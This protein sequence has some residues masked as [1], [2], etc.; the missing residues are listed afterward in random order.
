VVCLNDTITF[1]LDGVVDSGGIKRVDCTAKTGI[2]P[3]EPTITWTITKPDGTTISGS[4]RVAAVPADMA[5]TYTCTFGASADRDCPPPPITIGPAA[6]TAQTAATFTL[7]PSSIPAKTAWAGM[8]ANSSQSDITVTWDPP[9]CVGRL[10]I[11]LLEGTGGYQ[12]PNQGALT[13]ENDTLWHYVAFDE[14][15]PVACEQPV[16][17]WIAAFKDN[18]EL[19]RKSVLVLPVHTFLTTGGTANFPMD[20]GYITWKYGGSLATTGGAF[21]GGVTFSGN[22]SVYC[23][24]WPFGDYAY[25][26]TNVATGAVTFGTSAF[27]G[28]ENQ[29]ASI[30]GHELVHASGVFSECT[31]YTWEFNNDAAT[32][33]FQCDSS[34]LAEVAQHVNCKCHDVCP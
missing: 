28:S 31:A 23:G 17:V 20:F 12:P 1:T 16:K 10:E 11:V 2:P 32:G 4:G 34:Y 29:A 15:A 5:G 22:V 13:K 33:I 26:C 30:I 25:A 18:V 24:T 6:V 3:V 7:D 19:T 14:P 9:Q 8:P 21:T 27:T